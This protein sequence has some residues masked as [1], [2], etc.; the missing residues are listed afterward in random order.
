[1]EGDVQDLTHSVGVLTVPLCAAHPALIQR[2][3][4]LHENPGYIKTCT[5]K[6]GRNHISLCLTLLLLLLF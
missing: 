3:P 1:M 4:V 5:R 6:T 2:V